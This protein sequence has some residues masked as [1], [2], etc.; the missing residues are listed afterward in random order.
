MFEGEVPAEHGIEYDP[1]APHVHLQRH[2]GLLAE[3]FR[4]GVA[5]ASAG[6]SQALVWAIEV[7]KSEVDEFDGFVLGEQYVLRFE[8]A[9]CNSQG[10]EILNSIEQLL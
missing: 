2:V 6:G 9:M 1:A 8:V 5:R 3:H 7:A 4:S 10:V